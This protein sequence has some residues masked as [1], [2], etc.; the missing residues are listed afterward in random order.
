MGSYKRPD[1]SLNPILQD[2]FSKKF[3]KKILFAVESESMYEGI[4]EFSQKN[5]FN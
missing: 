4:L 2:S 3:S 5:C 1:K